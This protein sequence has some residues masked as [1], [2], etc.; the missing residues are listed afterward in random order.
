M[1]KIL[2]IVLMIMLCLNLSG[3]FRLGIYKYKGKIGGKQIHFYEQILANN[4]LNLKITESDA[5]TIYCA[6]SD[7][8][9]LSY[10]EIT[11]EGN[12]IRY[13]NDEIGQEII[14]IGQLQFDEYLKKITEI[15]KAKGL[16]NLGSK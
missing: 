8:L 10:I 6:P 12:T 4:Y 1:K 16:K 15:K 11:K 2:V 3:C 9:K 7:N 14:K 13:I 5:L